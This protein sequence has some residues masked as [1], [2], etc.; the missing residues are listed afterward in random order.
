MADINQKIN[1][2][3]ETDLEQ[4]KDDVTKLGELYQQSV[5]PTAQQGALSADQKSSLETEIQERAS[6]I[7]MEP[8]ELKRVL[9]DINKL[10]QESLRIEQQ[11]QELQ[12]KNTAL[13]EKQRQAKEDETAAL[14]RA[15]KLLNLPLDATRQQIELARQQIR[16]SK[17][18]NLS[19]KERQEI[20]AGV[21]REF[22]V[23]QGAITR[24]NNALA[25]QQQNVEQINQN[26]TQQGNIIDRVRKRYLTLTKT[27]EERETVEGNVTRA[28][29]GQRLEI[30]RNLI[31]SK[32]IQD[33]TK[34]NEAAQ[35]E[36]ADAIKNTPDSFGGK[37]ASAFLYFQALTAVKRVAREAVRTLTELDKA[38]TDIAVVTTMTRKQT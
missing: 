14:Q 8:E 32:K 1:L 38:L 4:A 5:S 20:Y 6:S 21:T 24:Q 16:T 28:I 35:K 11:N 7:G 34:K 30:D 37:V 19:E 33:Q 15:A 3:F 17:E 12:D 9:E 22:K 2:Q 10:K 31:V 18:L 27:V 13:I 29:V 26:T 36:Y 25:A 23:A